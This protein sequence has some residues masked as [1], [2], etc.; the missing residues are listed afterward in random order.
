MRI[1]GDD[2]NTVDSNLDFLQE[3]IAGEME[4]TKSSISYTIPKAKA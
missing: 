1:G 4:V 2:A 3:L